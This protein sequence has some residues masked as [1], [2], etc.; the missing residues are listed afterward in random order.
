MKVE[1]VKKD[2]E[3]KIKVRIGDIVCWTD[4]EKEPCLVCYRT[5]VNLAD[6]G[7]IWEFGTQTHEDFIKEIER[8]IEEGKM[9]KMDEV[10]KIIL[11]PESEEV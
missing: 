6:P 2:K 11:Y 8:L 5:L 4:N 3:K 7:M 1:I 10:E 9:R